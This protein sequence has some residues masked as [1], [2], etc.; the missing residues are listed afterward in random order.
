METTRYELPACIAAFRKGKNS[1]F[2]RN[3]DNATS[4]DYVLT[5]GV[6]RSISRMRLAARMLDNTLDINE[7]DLYVS[8]G[9]GSAQA[10]IDAFALW[11][12]IWFDLKQAPS[13]RLS[14]ARRDFWT[15]IQAAL[16]NRSA[17]M[18]PYIEQLR[19]LQ[20]EQIDNY[21]QATQHWQGLEMRP[22]YPPV[23]ARL[24]NMHPDPRPWMIGVT[25]FSKRPRNSR[26]RTKS[27]RRCF[28]ASGLT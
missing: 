1:F 2:P 19:T 13:P 28:C 14:L 23:V 27:K 15:L 12:N 10:A 5:H 3:Q 9:V 26:S 20:A 8:A 24:E 7:A 4:W 21:R 25:I 18:L 6:G 11:L 16:I 17:A 22:S